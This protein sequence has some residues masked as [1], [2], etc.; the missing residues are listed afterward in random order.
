VYKCI[1]FLGLGGAGQR[2][3]R[4]LRERLPNVRMIGARR[5]G[6]TPVLNSDFTVKNGAT[7]ESEYDI[8]F[9]KDVNEAY[10]QNPDLVVIATPTFDHAESIIKAAKHKA[11][12][13]VE[14][15]GAM[16]IK[17][18]HNVINTVKDNK[19][20]FFVSYQRRFHPLVGRLRSVLD[21]NKIGKLMSVRVAVSSY[22]PD[23]HP[24][25]DFHD[26]YAC[27]SDLG[28]GVLKTETHEI[29]FIT[30]L[31]GIP[32][33]IFSTYG[34]RGKFNIDVED[35]ANLLLDYDSFSVQMSMCFMQK[36]QE[37]N[38]KFFGQ[39]GWIEFDLINQKLVVCSYDNEDLEVYEDIVANDELFK[40][41]ADYF[42]NKFTSSDE[43]YLKALER[44]TTIIE[45]SLNSNY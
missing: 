13:L 3:L 41:Q 26:L 28:G 18:A 45:K 5:T 20:G 24:Y 19:V 42:L 12:I 22:M 36:K 40:L 23:W 2:H 37:R 38:F 14:K 31:F 25:E 10:E 27:R 32:R 1:L 8:E 4:I 35:S 34:C 21:S 7:L 39:K 9:F 17:Q 30:W 43:H 15:P 6:N 16:N 33:Q 11:N 44:N 29:D